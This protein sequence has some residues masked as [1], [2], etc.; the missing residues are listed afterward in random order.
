MVQEPFAVTQCMTG[1]IRNTLTKFQGLCGNSEF[2]I[3]NMYP[4]QELQIKAYSKRC[5]FKI[6]KV[7]QKCLK[8]L[9]LRS[10]NNHL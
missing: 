3:P 4:N 6:G 10:L 1:V 8:K 9:N 5:Q 7:L 2:K